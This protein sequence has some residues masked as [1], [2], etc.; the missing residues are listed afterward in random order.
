M[1][2]FAVGYAAQ[3]PRAAV[4]WPQGLVSFPDLL[5]GFGSEGGKKGRKCVYCWG[6]SPAPLRDLLGDGC[7]D[8]RG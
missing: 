2:G 8:A 1:K 5:M 7:G 4:G 3:V 6:R